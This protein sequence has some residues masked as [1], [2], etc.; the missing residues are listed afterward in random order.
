MTSTPATTLTHRDEEVLAALARTPLT[1][2]QLLRYSE[3]FAQPFTHERLVRRRLQQLGAR[4]WVQCWQYASTSHGAVNYY[5]LTTAGYRLLNGPDAV[6]PG[7][8]FFQP[9]SLALQQHTQHLAEFIVQSQR[10]A[11]RAHGVELLQYYRDGQLVL[12]QDQQRLVPDGGMQLK[13]RQRPYNFLV[14]IDCGSEPVRSG[15][16]RDSLERKLRL[17]DAYHQASP[18]SFRVLTLFTKA[19]PRMAHFLKLADELAVHRNRRLFYAAPLAEYNAHRDPLFAPL[20]LDHTLA[21]VSLLPMKAAPLY[22]PR[23]PRL[24]EALVPC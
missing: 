8:G 14:E 1:A 4:G 7:R 6:L 16:E 3:T 18:G 20:F 22:T 11:H 13:C 17:Y 9:V 23:Q 12:E 5:K 15:K 2:D 10:A 21:P 24:D 19:G